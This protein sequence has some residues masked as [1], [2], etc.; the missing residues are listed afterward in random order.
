MDSENS[1]SG[2]LSTVATIFGI[3][4]GALT[5]IA[6]LFPGRGS[7]LETL[8]KLL[9]GMDHLFSGVA[10]GVAQ[11]SESWPLG[12]WLSA[13]LIFLVIGILRY[14]AEVVFDLVTVDVTFSGVV[15]QMVIFLPLALL[16]IWVFSGVTTG[17]GVLAFLGGYVVSITSSILI[18]SELAP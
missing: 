17:L 5:I 3:L 16:W 13:L 7:L 6:Y 12:P 8:G 14:L 2:C 4:T 10:R 11:F 15:G 18:A 1:A 9:P